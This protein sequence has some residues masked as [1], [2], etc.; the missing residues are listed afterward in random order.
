MKYK[1]L[2]VAALLLIMA[3]TMIVDTRSAYTLETSYKISIVPD[4]RY[5]NHKSGGA[6][7]SMAQQAENSTAD[8][9]KL[10]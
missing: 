8:T 2:L 5:G 3:I 7:E 4:S 9:I 10:Q 1:I 6:E